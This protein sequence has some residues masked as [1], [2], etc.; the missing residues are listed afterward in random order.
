MA[1]RFLYGQ[2]YVSLN[3]PVEWQDYGVDATTNDSFVKAAVNTN[4]F[5]FVGLAARFI[6]NWRAEIGKGVFNGIPF[7]IVYESNKV[8]G[9]NYVIFD[10]FINLSDPT[11]ELQS[12]QYPMR[13]VAPIVAIEDN[14]NAIEE[15]AVVTQG[16]LQAKG[17]LNHTHYV[18]IPVIRESKKNIAE[19]A[20]IL[21]GFG[22]RVVVALTQITSN[23]V[24]ALGNTLGVAVIV[25]VVELLLVF[26]NA[27]VVLQQLTNEGLQMKDLFFP[28]I[29]Y[30]KGISI[31]TLLTQ[32]FDYKNKV[33]DFGILDDLFSNSYLLASQNEEN[34]FP[35]QGLPFTGLFKRQDWG[36]IIGE[37]LEEI[38]KIG[39]TRWEV[40]DG[41]AHI[42]SRKDPFWTTSPA[43]VPDNVLIKSVEQY[44]NGIYKDDAE[45]VKGTVMVNFAYDPTD[46]H[47]LT[48]KSGDSFEI[49]RSLINELN[50]EMNTLKGIQEIEVRWA[51]CVRKQAFDNLW[52]LFTG[53]CGVWDLYLQGIKDKVNQFIGE[54]NAS[55]VGIS[56]QITQILNT[57][58]LDSFIA[59]R[60]GCLKI[61]D[62]A[63]AIPKIV[64][65]TDHG[66]E[67]GLRIPTDF[68]N[69]IGAEAIYNDWYKWDSPADVSNFY[70]QKRLVEGLTNRWSYE[71]FQQT[72]NNPFFTLDGK[73]AKFTRVNWIEAKH[74]ATCEFEIRDPF[75]QNIT[76][77]EIDI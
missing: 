36:Y 54:L 39:N 70:G 2:S 1:Q 11:V 38:E 52:D 24:G 50:P 19:R 67:L 10:G 27:V 63:Y 64:Y 20:M 7:R 22:S 9:D 46:T 29:S 6:L 16:V 51:M 31:K 74:Q 62:N 3:P 4:Q 15:M 44:Q 32:A 77:E 43:F 76:E 69:Y 18:D 65:M 37:V 71:K 48:Q 59:N 75:D 21:T 28:Q 47:T 60:S 73:S 26:V 25:G 49:R 72:L 34:G 33:A 13:V 55:G 12:L 41:V 8:P 56:T 57:T 40:R 30:Y 17:F 35:V 45:G 53:V 58:G 23:I 14:K 61:D 68:K 5:T 42:K 66:S